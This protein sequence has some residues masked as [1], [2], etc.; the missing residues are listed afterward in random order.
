MSR[1]Q[2]IA[3]YLMLLSGITHPAQMLFYGTD[4]EVRGPAMSGIIFFFVGLG[5]L[6]RF[7]LAL[8]VAIVL[9][10]LGGIG[11]VNRILDGTPTA[12]TYFHAVVD[13]VVIGL[14]V[15]ALT[16][17]WRKPAATAPI[18]DEA[19]PKKRP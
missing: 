7:R 4:P 8:V 3:A 11:A 1:Y 14:C 12:F 10:L 2:R 17:G 9:P 18:G 6:T 13:F 15:A 5:L 19:C 16:A